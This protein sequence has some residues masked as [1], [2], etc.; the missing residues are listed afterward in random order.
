MPNKGTGF[1]PVEI[2]INGKDES[3]S[4][5]WVVPFQNRPIGRQ[6]RSRGIIKIRIDIFIK[7][8]TRA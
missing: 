8:G 7:G 4:M 6:F 5:D 2:E 1:D 3:R